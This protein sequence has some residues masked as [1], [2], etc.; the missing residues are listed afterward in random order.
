M[1]NSS[2]SSNRFLHILIVDL[3]C[4]QTLNL[5]Y[6][7]DVIKP[8]PVLGTISV[9]AG[10]WNEVP[11]LLEHIKESVTSEPVRFELEAA[12]GEEFFR[13]GLLDESRKAFQ[14][15]VK[16]KKPSPSMFIQ[17]NSNLR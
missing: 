2:L 16:A 8:F 4:L 7:A 10:H 15:L 12:A 6:S 11:E 1:G 14:R 9:P 13:Q 17:Q 3:L 5:G